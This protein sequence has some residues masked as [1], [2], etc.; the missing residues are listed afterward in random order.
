MGTRE[1]AIANGKKGGRPP[2]ALNKMSKH[3]ALELAKSNETPLDVMIDN[4]NFWRGEATRL[5]HRV[6]EVDDLIL[7][8]KNIDVNEE[9]MKNFMQLL[10]ER[11]ET[12]N[13][14]L[15]ARQESQSCAVAA[16]PYVHPKFTSISVKAQINN[17]KI[18][19]AVGAAITKTIEDDSKPVLTNGH[20][21]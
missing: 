4:M 8:F 7:A 12:L 9:T 21:A 11:N 1:V 20:A 16:A 14:M 15:A 17:I 6:G 18:Q 5:T 10:K 3:K 2:G 13:K 19:M